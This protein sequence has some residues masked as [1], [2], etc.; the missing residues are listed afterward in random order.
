[1]P[2]F[3]T[4]AQSLLEYVKNKHPQPG[5]EIAVIAPYIAS[6]GDEIDTTLK[7]HYHALVEDQKNHASFTD[8][9]D[10]RV[11]LD[12]LSYNK[13]SHVL[14]VEIATAFAKEEAELAQ[15][16]TRKEALVLSK[17]PS[18]ITL[19]EASDNMEIFIEKRTWRTADDPS[20]SITQQDMNELLA[21]AQ[22][23]GVSLM[24]H[25]VT[26][27]QNS[28]DVLGPNQQLLVSHPVTFKDD[29]V[30]GNQR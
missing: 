22:V 5:E 17:T 26:G 29:K 9:L 10:L 19:K 7:H 15:T 4:Q 12:Q 6:L 30:N 13:F 24:I 1:M 11:L 23:Q 28:I 2:D 25:N 27:G 3:A 18:K 8:S 20:E 16:I 21:L 14:M